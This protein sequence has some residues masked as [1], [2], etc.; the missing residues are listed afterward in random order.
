M[1]R[2]ILYII[3]LVLV[4]MCFSGCKKTEPP[5]LVTKKITLDRRDFTTDADGN[6]PEGKA[7][8]TAVYYSANEAVDSG[9]LP[10]PE[11]DVVPETPE[12]V[13]VPET[14]LETDAAPADPNAQLILD[15]AGGVQHQNIADHLS[16][17]CYQIGARRVG[18]DGNTQAR[19]YII[20]QLS[21]FGYSTGDST[22]Y[23][24]DFESAGYYTE[25]VI[26]RHRTATANPNYLLVSA[27]YDTVRGVQGAIDNAS[28]IA[29]LLEAARVIHASGIDFGVE[30][31][32]A[33]FSG[34]ED[35]YNGAKEYIRRQSADELAR[36]IGILNIDMAGHANSDAPKALVVS[37]KG[38]PS[39]SD[40]N[41]AQPNGISGAI[42][43]AYYTLDDI[44][45]ERYYSPSNAGKHDIVPF[46]KIGMPCATVS[47]R[48]IDFARAFGN[49]LGIAAP[50]FIHTEQDN[51]DNLNIDSV[52]RT[53]RLVVG[54]V[55][56]IAG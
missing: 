55:A 16:A 17:L 26:A 33:F 12:G 6:S 27:H 19:A 22:I 36:Y 39:T 7:E 29:L 15:L 42:V 32:F 11:R 8:E 13:A 28:G 53:T 14:A 18:T 10:D 24:Q 31:R 41:A 1:K 38:D 45:A 48:E 51:L 30:I 49:D 4:L 5:P 52:Y 40:W 23:T 21:A 46:W 47:W 37:T 2:A 54:A 50:S 25:N 9:T 34:E 35:G 56:S 43:N 3:V 20:D 44:G